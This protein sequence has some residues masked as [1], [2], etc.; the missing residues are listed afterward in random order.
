[1]IGVRALL[2]SAAAR[3]NAA[4]FCVLMLVLASGSLAE[5]QQTISFNEATPD[6][7]NAIL[8][9]VT[10]SNG[11]GFRFASDHF[12]LLG[13]G[14]GAFQDFSTNG[15]NAIGYESGRGFPI[16][17]ERVGAG[18]FSLLGLDAAEF[19]IVDAE[20]P[21]ADVLTITGYQQGGGVVTHTV[22]LDDVHDG[23]GGLPDFQH[24]DLPNTFVNLVRVVFSGHLN[25][26]G[27][28][29]VT[30]DNLVY[31]LAQPEV[32]APCVVT[33]LP[34][35]TPA[36]SITS[37]SAGNVSGTVTITATAADNS[38]ISGVQFKVDGANVGSFD[39]SA[40]YS[41]QWDST[42]WSDGP[43]TISAEATA[44]DG[45]TGAASVIV[46]AVNGTPTNQDPAYLDFD[47]IDD[48]GL[49]SDADA[50]SFG[51]GTADMPFTFEAWIRPDTI[52]AKQQILGKWGDQ[53][54]EY[55]L[56][57]ASGVIR[58]DLRDH[59]ANATVSVYTNDQAALGGA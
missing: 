39:T 17:M 24:F 44:I 56:Y 4:A 9:E 7:G 12:H 36:V 10:C 46:T 23:P 45:G 13:F 57:T 1:M 48:Y 58:L 55:R 22:T 5:A 47:G 16:E 43:H 32:L 34:P 53:P 40:P 14:T 27:D 3:P 30:V 59:S 19:Y 20:R 35:Q 11:S 49:V 37:P 33:P 38:G 50:L 42:A 28:G 31:Q 52:T 18:T 8:G 2:A 6:A 25:G 29:G 41:V 15:T 26:G 21:N 51:N 54:S